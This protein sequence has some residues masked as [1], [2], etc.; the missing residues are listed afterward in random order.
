VE[1]GSRTL[2]CGTVYTGCRCDRRP[3]L[4]SWR[5]LKVLLKELKELKKDLVLSGRNL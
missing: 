4:T 2:N 5:K 3:N 1:Y